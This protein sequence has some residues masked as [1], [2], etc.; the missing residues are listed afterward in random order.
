MDLGSGPNVAAL[1]PL[2]ANLEKR[3]IDFNIVPTDIDF[4]NMDSLLK[5]PNIEKT[6]Y[7]D[8]N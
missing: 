4:M 5:L 6:L 3:R 7:F 2:I 1:E 8:L